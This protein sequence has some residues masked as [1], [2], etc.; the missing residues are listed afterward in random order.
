[1][2][3]ALELFHSNP[4]H[5][6]PAPFPHEGGGIYRPTHLVSTD[7][8]HFAPDGVYG[9]SQVIGKVAD[10][11]PKDSLKRQFVDV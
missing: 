3:S 8:T 5:Y 9:A 1:M 7:E 4:I 10:Y 2:M 11:D 6:V